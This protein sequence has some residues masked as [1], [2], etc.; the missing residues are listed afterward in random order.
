VT[1]WR[2]LVATAVPVVGDAGAFAQ[3]LRLVNCTARQIDIADRL[4]LVGPGAGD[5]GTLESVL[6]SGD[7]Y[8]EKRATWIDAR[9]NLEKGI[10]PKKDRAVENRAKAQTE[11]LKQLM[12]LVTLRK[13]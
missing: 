6:K 1:A 5:L 3:R 12:K 7:T 2:L 9:I 11:T 10:L 13:L 4:S 8:Y